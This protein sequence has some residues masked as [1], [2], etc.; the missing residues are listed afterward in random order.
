MTEFQFSTC[1]QEE[2]KISYQ[3]LR[4]LF[5]K[6]MSNSDESDLRQLARTVGSTFPISFFV[7]R[8]QRL[9]SLEDKIYQ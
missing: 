9:L 4:K 6:N 1:S 2:F 5:P 3:I 7:T 8:D